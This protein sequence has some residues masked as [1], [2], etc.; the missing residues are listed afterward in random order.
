MFHTF[1]TLWV[2]ESLKGTEYIVAN[3]LVKISASSEIWPTQDIVGKFSY[4]HVYGLKKG[5]F[6]SCLFVTLIY[7]FLQ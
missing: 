6:S 2:T 1:I 7:I 3:S 4:M 5:S